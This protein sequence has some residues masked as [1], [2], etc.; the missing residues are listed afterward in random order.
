MLQV[1]SPTEFNFWLEI[2]GKKKK[3]NMNIYY[4]SSCRRAILL[5]SPRCE[6]RTTRILG[7]AAGQTR[8]GGRPEATP[9]SA[10]PEGEGTGKEGAAKEATAGQGEGT[11][12]G[13]KTRRTQERTKMQTRRTPTKKSPSTPRRTTSET[14]KE[15]GTGHRLGSS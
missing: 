12:M 8:G 10:S 9:E 15:Q 11:G 13:K 5:V 1:P 6:D 3:K 2:I 7:V 14:R 4:L